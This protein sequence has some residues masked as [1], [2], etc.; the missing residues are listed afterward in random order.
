MHRDHL[1]KMW[2]M[3]YEGPHR[4]LLAASGWMAVQTIVK[5]FRLPGFWPRVLDL[6]AEG[7]LRI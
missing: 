2:V 7:H 1:V 3:G 6:E 4:P 5:G